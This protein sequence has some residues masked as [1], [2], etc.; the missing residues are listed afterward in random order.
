MLEEGRIQV[1]LMV[2]MMVNLVDK[3]RCV[4]TQTTSGR[5][6]DQSGDQG[7]GLAQA[8]N[9]TTTVVETVDVA[10]E[11]DEDD[12]KDVTLTTMTKEDKMG[13]KVVELEVV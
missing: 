1:A 3:Y 10:D 13:W 9:Q 12:D 5:S 6:V 2:Q 4:D 7:V 11:A 8:R